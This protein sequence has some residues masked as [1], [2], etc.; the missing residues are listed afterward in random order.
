MKKT[1]TLFAGMLTL[2]CCD[3][4]VSPG[5]GPGFPSGTTGLD[6]FSLVGDPYAPDELDGDE[7]FNAGTADC[8]L[9]GEAM[10]TH[11]ETADGNTQEATIHY[12]DCK[13]DIGGTVLTLNGEAHFYDISY[14]V[15]N[16]TIFFQQK[17]SYSGDIGFSADCDVTADNVGSEQNITGG[18]TFIDSEDKEI[19]LTQEQLQSTLD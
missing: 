14:G 15:D 18:C 19:V 11:S 3:G 2:L 13:A 17:V 1:L 9:G 8:A 6:L 7:I 10:A 16:E 4:S 5:T 12:T